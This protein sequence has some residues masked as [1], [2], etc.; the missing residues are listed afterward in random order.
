MRKL[1]PLL[2][3]MFLSAC[4]DIDRSLYSLSNTVAPVDRVTGQRSLNLASR[5]QQIE[6]SN[7]RADG[8]LKKFM[9]ARNPINEQVDAVQFDRL[10]NVFVRV[11]A[12]S[13]LKEERWNAYL[14][15]DKEFNAFT[16]GG[17]YIFVNKGAM[18]NLRSDDELAA[19][20]GHEIAHVTA[21][22]ISEQ[23]AYTMAASLRGSKGVK[24][25]SF[26]A[27]FTLKNEEEADEVGTLYATLAGYDP[28]AASRVWKR[29]YEHTGDFSAMAINHPIHSQRYKRT[30]E[31]AKVYN[32]YYMPGRQNPRYAE[33]L[34][35]N[36][37]FGAAG[38]ARPQA[39]PGQGGGVLAALETAAN[40][41]GSHQAAKTEQLNQRATQQLIQYVTQSLTVRGRRI[42]DNNTLQIAFDYRGEVPV[43]NVNFQAKVGKEIAIYN[44]P[45]SVVRPMSSFVVSFT[46][47]SADLRLVDLNSIPVGLVHVERAK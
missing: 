35:T 16:M 37:V 40:V 15:P 47:K 22:H 41:M 34:A 25:E 45:D 3:M 43:T 23:S 14:L 33:I 32:Q 26:Q 6:S 13:H 27:A 20:I 1:L 4:A 18:D 38:Q 42:G 39:A 29:M 12:V 21:N 2:F 11:H 8:M 5:Q 10:Q 19:V 9:E 17:T 36:P 31:L 46:F 24:K 28:Y 44:S 30:L 7:A